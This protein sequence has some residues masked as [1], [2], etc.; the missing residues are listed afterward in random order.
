MSQPDWQVICSGIHVR[1]H[2]IDAVFSW[3]DKMHRYFGDDLSSAA[4]YWMAAP[5][6]QGAADRLF[7]DWV[8][9]RSEAR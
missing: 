7:A 3:L 6:D 2:E 9:Q 1:Q 4:V 5:H 8:A